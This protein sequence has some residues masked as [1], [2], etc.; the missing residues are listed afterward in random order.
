MWSEESRT[1]EICWKMNDEGGK[2]EPRR[3]E[4]SYSARREEMF[5]GNEEGKK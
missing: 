4:I 5:L 1:K 3:E 2:N